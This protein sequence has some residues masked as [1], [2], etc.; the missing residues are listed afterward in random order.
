MKEKTV[1]IKCSS[2]EAL[3]RLAAE[4]DIQDNV[5]V[6]DIE[7]YFNLPKLS[8]WYKMGVIINNETK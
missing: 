2:K 1:I 3:E 8:F 5:F 4:Y 7:R 6:G